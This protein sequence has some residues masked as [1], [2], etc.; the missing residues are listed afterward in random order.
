[1]S[2]QRKLTFSQRQGLEPL[3]GPLALEELSHEARNRLW[4]L[5]YEV[6]RTNTSRKGHVQ[7][8]WF[9]VLYD[10]HIEFLTQ[11]A[12][13]YNNNIY[14]VSDMY[15]GFFLNPK[16]AY[17]IIFDVLEFFMR[18][19]RCL[20]D[21]IG[22]VK[23]VFSDCR[24]AYII[25]TSGP[26]TIMPAATPQEGESIQQALVDL[27]NSGLV[28]ATKHLRGAGQHINSGQWTASVRESIHAVESVAKT[29]IED[30]RATLTDAL[31]K[32]RD[33]HWNV[34]PAFA[35]AASS[36]Y[37]WTSDEAGVRHA[38]TA[39]MDNVGKAEAVFMLGACASF[40][41][42]LIEKK[43]EQDELSKGRSASKR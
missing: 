6:T 3:P 21:F 18:H 36:L 12:D 31:R 24:L 17:N 38:A 1:M 9:R 32:L 13:K 39:K 41:T 27:A 4:A 20:P 37:G 2:E 14:V 25:D 15:K 19:P 8:P 30:D 29:V 7:G 11:P 23:K 5:F 34:H 42:Y 43:R 26:A 16:S 35:K 10:F 40:C 22:N 28:G 33:Q